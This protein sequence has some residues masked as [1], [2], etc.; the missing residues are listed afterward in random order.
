MDSGQSLSAGGFQF[1]VWVWLALFL[2]SSVFMTLLLRSLY[3][4]LMSASHQAERLVKKIENL[5]IVELEIEKPT[6]SIDVDPAIAQARAQMLKRARIK[7]LKQR[8]RRLGARRF[9][10]DEGGFQ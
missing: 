9:E 10:S 4:R 1:W 7:K 2:I 3:N 5:N 8:Q 6:S